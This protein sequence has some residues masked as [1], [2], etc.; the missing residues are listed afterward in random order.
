MPKDVRL[1]RPESVK[2]TMESTTGGE[3]NKQQTKSSSSL[4]Q[5]CN[6]YFHLQY[7]YSLS[8]VYAPPYRARHSEATPMQI[9]SS[10]PSFCRK[11]EHSGGTL[12]HIV[13]DRI[14]NFCEKGID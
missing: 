9:P 5:S 1:S 4:A 7:R 14:S 3:H 8:F 10:T 6:L 13:I 11:A 12:Y 2:W